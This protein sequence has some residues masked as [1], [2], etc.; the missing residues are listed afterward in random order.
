MNT[1]RDQ[2]CKFGHSGGRY[3]ENLAGGTSGTL[4]GQSVTQMW[5]DEIKQYSFPNG[6]FS[7]QTGHFTQ[8]VWRETTQVGCAKNTCRGMDIWI[9]NYDPPG[10]V[11]GGYRQNVVPAGCK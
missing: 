1:L 3:G 4:D 7:M 8:V 10:N 6:G 2:G 11:Q 5:Y 9:C